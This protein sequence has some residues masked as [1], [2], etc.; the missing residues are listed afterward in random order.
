M[1]DII[2]P[3][4]QEGTKAVVKTWLKKIGDVV[5]I[6]DPLVELETDKVAVEI[7]ATSAGTLSEILI[8]EGAEVEPGTVLGRVSAEGAASSTEKATAQGAGVAAPK[9]ATPS[10]KPV[11]DA[12]SLPPGIRKMLADN[13]LE[14]RDVPMSSARL[15]RED[16][17][18]ELDRRA[19]APIA[20]V[21]RVPHDTMRKRIAEHL[22]HSVTVAPHVTA[23]F[24][25]DFSAVAAHRAVHKETFARDGANL[26][27]TP[28]FVMASVAAMKTAPAVNGRWYDDRIDIYDDVNIGIGTALGE[29]GLIVPVI[30]RAQTLSL[31]QIAKA[32]TDVTERARGS[33]LNQDDVRGGTF[34]ISNHGVSGSLVATP[35][36]INQPQSA[37]LGVGK[38][39]KRAVVRDDA[40]V[41]RP[42]AYVT[43][44]I[45]HRVIDAFQ[46]NAWLTKFVET[47][48]TWPSEA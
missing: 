25:A 37:I 22:T 4:E 12:A 45:D 11:S 23:V 18:A 42:M 29:K 31:L 16:I 20:G 46:T 15:T 33:K 47:L 30:H 1:T 28:Y 35:I 36:I 2:V 13:N 3:T 27:Y 38:L 10:A 8:E 43:L 24:E 41:I 26:T 39:E 19:K 32:L 5:R 48:E 7:A 14:P 17:Q 6:D 34:S 40:V 21:T 44:T 9:A